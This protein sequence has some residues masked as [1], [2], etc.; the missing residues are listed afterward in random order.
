M[1]GITTAKSW[2]KVTVIH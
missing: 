2:K 1:A